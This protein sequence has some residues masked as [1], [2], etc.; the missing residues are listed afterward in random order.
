MP[1]SKPFLSFVIPPA[2]LGA[3]D[4]FRFK[5]K[6]TSRAQAI[7]WLLEFALKQKPKVTQ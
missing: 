4:E 7:L 3:V 6:F 1:S 5:N 2:L